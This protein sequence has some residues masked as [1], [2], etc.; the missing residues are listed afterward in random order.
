MKKKFGKIITVVS[1]FQDVDLKATAKRLKQELACG[2][3]VRD[4]TIELQGEHV[5]EARKVLMK[6]GFPEESIEITG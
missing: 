6:L 4:K 3:T 2:G 5:R 1:G